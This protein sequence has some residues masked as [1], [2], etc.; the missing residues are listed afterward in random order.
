MAGKKWWKRKARKVSEKGRREKVSMKGIKGRRERGGGK[1]QKRK[2][3]QK[4]RGGARRGGGT[5]EVRNHRW[6]IVREM[7]RVLGLFIDEKT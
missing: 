3:R 1:S 2:E 7:G 5:G 4:K 6:E